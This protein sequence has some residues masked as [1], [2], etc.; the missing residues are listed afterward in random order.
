MLAC[1]HGNRDEVESSTR[2]PLPAGRGSFAASSARLPVLQRPYEVPS[3]RGCPARRLVRSEGSVRAACLHGGSTPA[4][5]RAKSSAR[6]PGS[7]R[8]YATAPRS[9]APRSSNG[10][11][12][13][14]PPGA[15]RSPECSAATLRDQTPPS[16]DGLG[17][18]SAAPSVTSIWREG[19]AARDERI[20]SRR[21]MSRCSLLHVR[22]RQVP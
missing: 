7:R 18:Q 14:S 1:V 8:S 5:I 17:C 20:G 9:G 2:P 3:R 22:S 13:P 12:R 10:A 11:V 4:P 21:R 6:P 19:A 15:R 16:R